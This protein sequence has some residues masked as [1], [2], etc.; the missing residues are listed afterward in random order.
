MPPGS[1]RD[2]VISEQI[3]AKV[4]LWA[5]GAG[6]VGGSLSQGSGVSWSLELFPQGSNKNL[7][8]AASGAAPGVAGGWSASVGPSGP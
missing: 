3:W 5:S 8:P 2:A 7:R 4:P 1:A 6:A